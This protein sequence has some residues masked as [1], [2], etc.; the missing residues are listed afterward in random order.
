MIIPQMT[1]QDWKD[2]SWWPVLFGW[3]GLLFGAVL[4]YGVVSSKTR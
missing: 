4:F 1:R 3:W 2:V